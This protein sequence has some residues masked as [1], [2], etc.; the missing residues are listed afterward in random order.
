MKKSFIDVLEVIMNMYRVHE[1]SW[2][3]EGREY[4]VDETQAATE[5]LGGDSNL[6]Y[7]AHIFGYWGNDVQDMAKYYGFTFSPEGSIVR[8]PDDF[9]PVQVEYTEDFRAKFDKELKE[10]GL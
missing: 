2:S 7:L 9:V 10:H 5:F 6:G 3:P 8:P 4:L 1:E